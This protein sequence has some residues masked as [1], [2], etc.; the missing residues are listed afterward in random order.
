RLQLELIDVVIKKS[1]LCQ[2]IS[3]RDM[4]VK[5][6]AK[7]LAAFLHLVPRYEM[8]DYIAKRR[9]CDCLDNHYVQI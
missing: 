5:K 4:S 2:R 7:Q 3:G 6:A 9:I 8:F 1:S